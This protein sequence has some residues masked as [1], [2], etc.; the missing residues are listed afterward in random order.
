M[1]TLH[2]R[3]VG[4]FAYPKRPHP[5]EAVQRMEKATRMII[6]TSSFFMVGSFLI[7]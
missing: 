7:K 6:Q 3:M 5:K 4:F 2:R 1:E